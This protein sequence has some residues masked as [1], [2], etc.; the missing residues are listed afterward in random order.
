MVGFLK[1]VFG[2]DGSRLSNGKAH[3]GAKSDVPVQSFKVDRLAE[4]IRYFPLGE[5]V[6]YYPE[7]MQSSALETIVLGYS[8][9]D[10][11][12][13]SPLNIRHQD[14]NGQEVLR[15][16]VDGHEQLVSDIKQFR[17]LIPYNEDDE[18]KRDYTRRAELGPRGAFRRS[19]TITLVSCT[20][21]GSDSTALRSMPN[22]QGTARITT[23]VH[24]A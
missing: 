6:Q 21:G 23:S 12:I 19:N 5:K 8:V 14:D 3:T 24:A 18:N 11:F 1:K 9:N 2:G 13:F 15:L 16:M 17:I 20:S 7:Y 10:H 22:N 4:L